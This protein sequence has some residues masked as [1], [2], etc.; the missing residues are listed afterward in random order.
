MDQPLQTIPFTW[1]LATVQILVVGINRMTEA[2][3]KVPTGKLHSTLHTA[4]SI[5]DL[6]EVLAVPYKASVIGMVLAT[7]R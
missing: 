6:Q 5:R 1:H 7:Q 4:P 3:T 2:Q